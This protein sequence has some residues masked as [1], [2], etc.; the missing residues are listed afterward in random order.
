MKIK[1]KLKF[2]ISKAVQKKSE[3][4]CAI[5]MGEIRRTEFSSTIRKFLVVE[6]WKP[7]VSRAF[8]TDPCAFILSQRGLG[9]LNGGGGG[10]HDGRLVRGKWWFD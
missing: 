9:P 3:E 2:T 10:L 6:P 7:F 4:L 5:V 1:V 8:A